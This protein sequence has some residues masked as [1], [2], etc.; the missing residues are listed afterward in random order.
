MLLLLPRQANRQFR[1]I[2][3]SSK[4]ASLYHVARQISQRHHT[5]LFPAPLILILQM[6]NL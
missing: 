1:D 5:N 6:R 2:T 4:F 3:T